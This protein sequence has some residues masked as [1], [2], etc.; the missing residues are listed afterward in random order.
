MDSYDFEI[1][2]KRHV[3]HILEKIF[4][5]LDYESLKKC[6]EVC[7]TWKQL[8]TSEK[9]QKKANFLFRIDMMKDYGKLYHAAHKG[10][11]TEVE[12]F[13]S[14]SGILRSQIV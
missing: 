2:F 4:F 10:N 5:Y 11:T 8:L 12:R 14:S 7:N 1:L 13:L 6:L 3:P 9:Y